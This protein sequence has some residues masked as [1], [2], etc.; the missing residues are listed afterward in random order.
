MRI[1]TSS[2]HSIAR[3]D[4]AKDPERLAAPLGYETIDGAIGTIIVPGTNRYASSA[5]RPPRD[6]LDK[7]FRYW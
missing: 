3:E 1:F 7:A 6:A 4:L 2:F 5:F